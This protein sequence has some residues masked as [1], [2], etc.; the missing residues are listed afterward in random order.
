MTYVWCPVQQTGFSDS[1]YLG[2]NIAIYATLA[3]FSKQPPLSL[4]NEI[5]EKFITTLYL[6]SHNMTSTCKDNLKV[7]TKIADHGFK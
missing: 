3:R 2:L 5:T 6:D 4:C 1:Y 7:L